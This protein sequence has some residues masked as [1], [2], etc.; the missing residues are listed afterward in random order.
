MLTEPL[1]AMSYGAGTNSTAMLIGLKQRGIKPDLI[2]FADTGG[3]RPETYKHLEIVSDWCVKNGF[4]QIIT[5]QQVNKYG[6][7]ITLEELCLKNKMLPSIAYGYKG[8]SLKH[9]RAPQDKY[10]NNWKPAREVWKAGGKVVKLIGYDFDEQRRA[11]I[12]DDEKYIYDYPLIDWKWGRDEC[13]DAIEKEGIPLPGKSACFFCPSSKKKE[14][15]KLQ[16]EHPELMARAIKM[17][18]NANLTSVKGLGRSYSWKELIY[19]S[20]AQTTLFN[21]SN[22][23]ID[24]GC[25]DGEE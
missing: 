16:E 13:I 20:G 14:V 4:P 8:C 10:V 25:Y 11:K 22:I 15:L 21:E 19:F 23:D 2:L 24:C 18:E 3:E 12:K 5:V 17:E 9:K 6:E 7:K 1:R